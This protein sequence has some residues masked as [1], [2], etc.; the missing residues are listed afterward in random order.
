MVPWIQWLHNHCL[1]HTV[2]VNALLKQA[3]LDCWRES[4]PHVVLLPIRDSGVVLWRFCAASHP[5]QRA[6]CP[7]KQQH[8]ELQ[9]TRHQIKTR[10]LAT[11]LETRSRLDRKCRTMTQLGSKKSRKGCTQCKKRRVKVGTSRT[12]VQQYS[13]WFQLQPVIASDAGL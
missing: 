13:I 11:R 4:G 6:C 8:Q 3:A 9:A 10:K 1:S 12:L 7:A 5:L 2:L